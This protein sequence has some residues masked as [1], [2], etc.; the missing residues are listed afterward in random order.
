MIGIVG[1]RNSARRGDLQPP[2]Q[3]ARSRRPASHAVVL[4][5]RAPPAGGPPSELKRG[6]EREAESS[7][8]SR[9]ECGAGSR[10]GR[11]GACHLRR[12]QRA[13][14]SPKQGGAGGA[15]GCRGAAHSPRRS[16]ACS[17]A[18]AGREASAAFIQRDDDEVRS[19]ARE[20]ATTARWM[21]RS[22][23]SAGQRSVGRRPTN[24]RSRRASCAGGAPCAVVCR[25]V[26]A[27]HCLELLL[28]REGL[29]VV[30]PE[31]AGFQEW[32]QS[33]RAGITSAVARKKLSTTVYLTIEHPLC[34]GSCRL[35]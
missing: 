24:K 10:P 17:P 22:M 20:A 5:E 35:A 27:R 1:I 32:R 26:T 33:C 11:I 34:Q 12:A 18:P 2:S 25:V 7:Q 14:S 29:R 13:V 30:G 21:R 16:S 23:R 4:K 28:K 19:N 31:A 8:S 3:R 15:S 6:A 9:G